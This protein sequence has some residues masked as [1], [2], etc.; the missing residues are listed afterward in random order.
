MTGIG[1]IAQQGIVST[2]VERMVADRPQTPEPPKVEATPP[3]APETGRGA[4][5]DTSA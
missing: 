4:Q 1:P 2:Q 5:I 3:P